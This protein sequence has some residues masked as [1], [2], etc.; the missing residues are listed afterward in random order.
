VHASK[1]E[2]SLLHL[3]EFGI[4]FGTFVL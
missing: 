3:Y 2:V 4:L 1:Y